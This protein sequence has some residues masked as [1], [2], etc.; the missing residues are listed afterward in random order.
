MFLNNFLSKHQEPSA[1]EQSLVD[2][3][4]AHI[5]L[6]FNKEKKCKFQL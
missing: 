1:V 2:I 4:K 3:I 5:K 6:S